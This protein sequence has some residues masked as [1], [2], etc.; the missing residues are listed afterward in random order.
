M[1][2]RSNDSLSTLAELNPGDIISQYQPKYGEEKEVTRHIVLGKH[3]YDESFEKL[4]TRYLTRYSTMI[5][6][7]FSARRSLEGH[8]SEEDL[9]YFKM[10]KIIYKSDLS[11]SD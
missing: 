1:K 11:W 5:I 3:T 10:W 9:R 6:Y 8:I 7:S 4:P 2:K